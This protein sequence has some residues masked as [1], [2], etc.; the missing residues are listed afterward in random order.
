MG[1]QGLDQ[2]AKTT[3]TFAA[4]FLEARAWDHSPAASGRCPGPSSD[5]ADLADHAAHGLWD[6]ASQDPPTPGLL[7]GNKV[8][9]GHAVF[10]VTAPTGLM[11]ARHQ[12]V[13]VL[14]FRL[15]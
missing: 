6:A 5:G 10:A 11:S 13:L 1:E 9:P 8:S 3:P 4:T 2:D 7:G 12:P 15:L 14:L